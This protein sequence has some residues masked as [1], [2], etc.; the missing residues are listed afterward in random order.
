MT[1]DILLALKQNI[2]INVNKDKVSYVCM[3]LCRNSKC[4][5]VNT[6]YEHMMISSWL[7]MR[8]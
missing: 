2:T 6:V 7:E 8:K 4:N 3:F 1:Y 5:N